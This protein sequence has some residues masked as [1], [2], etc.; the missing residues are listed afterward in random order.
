MRELERPRFPLFTPSPACLRAAVLSWMLAG[1]ALA[2][3]ELGSS[4][5]TVFTGSAIRF[6][7]IPV[8]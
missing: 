3:H 2:G 5:K 1:I 7:S 4:D 6:G 8:V